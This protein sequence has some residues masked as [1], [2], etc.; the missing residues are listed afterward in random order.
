MKKIL[1]LVLLA[2][3]FVPDC[4]A[5]NKI[6]QPWGVIPGGF[7]PEKAFGNN[8]ASEF[9][10]S[11]MRMK[12]A[13]MGEEV[14][15]GLDD[16][17]GTIFLNENFVLGVLYDNGEAFKRAYLRY[18]AYNDEVELKESSDSDTV[19][20]MVKNAVYSCS[21]DGDIFVYADFTDKDGE[22][23]KGYLSV[24]VTGEDYLLFERR[25]KVFKEGKEAKTS[26]DNSFPHRF[27]DKTE[28]YVS[29][30]GDAPVFLK[31]RKSDVLSMFSEEDQKNIK[32]YFKEKRPN[33]K[34]G[35]D[36]LNL[37]TYANTL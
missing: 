32:D 21:I 8:P 36:L 15:L 14:K 37:F 19:R 26:L 31:T 20:S 9:F 11:D 27:L 28:Y 33:V 3:L 25:M 10:Y 7:D 24:L 30:N 5:Q 13:R 17:E 23:K 6:I 22:S 18:D 16:I 4:I 2:L 34:D 1:S 29:V 12:F 35:D